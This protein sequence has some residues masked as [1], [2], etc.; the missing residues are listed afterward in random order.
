M[1]ETE[2]C[3]TTV[4]KYWCRT[5]RGNHSPRSRADGLSCCFPRG[6]TGGDRAM[7][8]TPLPGVLAPLGPLL[9]HYGYLAVAGLRADGAVEVRRVP[10]GAHRQLL[11]V[12]PGLR[13]V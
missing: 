7:T 12:Q 8:G 10:A 3:T 11:H 5:G 2:A 9:D 13:G 1:V 4:R 6:W